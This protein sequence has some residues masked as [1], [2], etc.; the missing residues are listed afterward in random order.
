MQKQ[1]R[2]KAGGGLVVEAQVDGAAQKLCEDPALTSDGISKHRRKLHLRNP[3][4]CLGLRGN[5]GMCDV[6]LQRP[7]PRP[8]EYGVEVIAC[9][10]LW[11]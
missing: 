2:E 10:W 5:Y 3:M 9:S 11:L 4:Y 8:C 7:R 1:E 6:Y